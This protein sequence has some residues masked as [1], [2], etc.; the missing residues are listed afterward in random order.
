MN[1]LELTKANLK[2][3][4]LQHR[5]ELVNRILLAECFNTTQKVELAV[6]ANSTF[7]TEAYA[8]QLEYLYPAFKV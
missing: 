2:I 3:M 6:V 8:S 1:T 4:S 7:D 5:K